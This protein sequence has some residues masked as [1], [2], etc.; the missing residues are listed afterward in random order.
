MHFNAI[1]I[2]ETQKQ[3]IVAIQNKVYE[4]ID[5]KSYKQKS[6]ENEK[7]DENQADENVENGAAKGYF[8]AFCL[9]FV[10][11]QVETFVCVSFVYQCVT[12]IKVSV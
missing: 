1:L 5:R 8:L 7:S 9:G 2:L 6:D 10:F 12:G 11:R 3:L 4:E